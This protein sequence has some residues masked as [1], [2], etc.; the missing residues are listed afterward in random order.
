MVAHR[1][2]HHLNMLCATLVLLQVCWHLFVLVSFFDHPYN[3]GVV[4]GELQPFLVGVVMGGSFWGNM[5]RTGHCCWYEAMVFRGGNRSNTNVIVYHIFFWI[6]LQIQISSDTN[7]KRIVESK[8][9]FGYLLNS[10]QTTY[11]KI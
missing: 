11:P 10:T 2:E 1:S 6:R 5:G 7:T 3:Y 4:V 9:L 8:F